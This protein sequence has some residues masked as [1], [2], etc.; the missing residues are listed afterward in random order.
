MNPSQQPEQSPSPSP[1]P[2]EQ[3]PTAPPAELNT[4]PVAPV[5][6]AAPLPPVEP[7]QS[8]APTPISQPAGFG[9]SVVPPSPVPA[10]SSH[11]KLIII[12]ACAVGALLMIGVA[13]VVITL[14][15]VSKKDYSAALSQYN[16]V[17]SA[18][19]TLD[20]KLSSLQY[21]VDSTTD[22]SFD[23]DMDAAEKA[24]AE[25]RAENVA[26]GKLKAVKVG[27]GATKYAAFTAKFD[28]Y[29]TYV[30]NQLTSLDNMREAS[31]T[32]EG[33]DTS[34]SS[35]SA[36]KSAL[37]ECVAALQKVSDTPDADIKAFIAKLKEEYTKLSSVMGQLAAITDPY[38]DQYDQYKSLRDQVY[39]IGDNISNAETDF[40]SNLEKH[41]DAVSPKDAADELTKFLESKIAG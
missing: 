26:L 19:Y 4:S 37:D 12:I 38:G 24:I 31:I 25:L 10:K 36:V 14:F 30:T 35:I 29:T 16:E 20:S 23:N 34:S 41:S 18:T 17:A 39:D 8:I 21:G 15:S 7:A 3:P 1:Q 33:S 32:C 28:A 27:E 22:T 11:K 9:G 40:R 2:Q 5:E 6:S 13:L